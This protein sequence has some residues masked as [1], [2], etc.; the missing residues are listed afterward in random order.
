MV[1]NHWWSNRPP[2]T[3]IPAQYFSTAL[4]TSPKATAAPPVISKTQWVLF[5]KRLLLLG[6]ILSFAWLPRAQAATDCTAVTEI[7]QLECEALVALYTSTDGANWSDSSD[8]NWNVTN[9]PCS[10]AGVTCTTEHVTSIHRAS[11][12]LSGAI[13]TGLGNLSQL[14]ALWLDHNQL[15]DSLPVSLMSLAGLGDFR[16]ND[17]NLCEPTETDFQNWL[18]SIDKLQRTG[19]QCASLETCHDSVCNVVP[20]RVEESLA[21]KSLAEIKFDGLKESY[22]V[23][24]TITIRVVEE[25]NASPR[26]ESVD[27]WVAMQMPT[28]ELFFKTPSSSTPFSLE[29]QP[30][31]TGV[32][33]SETVHQV[34]EFKVPPG[35]E[36]KYTLF[37]IYVQ[38]G[39]NPLLQ[40]IRVIQRSNLAVSAVV[41]RDV[42]VS[43]RPLIMRTAQLIEDVR[44]S[45]AAPGWKDARLTTEVFPLYRPDVEGIAYY[46]LRVLVPQENGKGLKPAGFVIVSTGAHDFPVV[47]WNFEGK[48]PV[49]DLTEQAA[50][51]GKRPHTFYKLDTLAYAVE[52]RDGNL[53]ATISDLPPKIIGMNM[54]LLD[55]EAEDIV[56][57][58]STQGKQITKQQK[59]PFEFGEWTSWAEFKNEYADTYAVLIEALRRDASEEWEINSLIQQH[60]EVLFR[61]DNYQLATLPE[62]QAPTFEL[63]GEGV[64]FVEVKL[65]RRPAISPV[66]SINVIAAPKEVEVPLNVTLNYGDA[67]SQTMTFR[68]VPDSL[69]SEIPQYPPEIDSSNQRRSTR[70][71]GSWHTYW[72][73]THGDQRWYNQILAG[74][75][76]NNSSCASGCGATAWGMLFGWGDYRAASGDPVWQH[77]WG[78]YR[79]DGGDGDDVVAPQ[80]MD[81][82]VKNMLWEIRNDIDT[83]CVGSSGATYPWKMQNA[84]EYLQSR[85][86]ADISTHYNPIGIPMATLRNHAVDSIV[87]RDTPAVIGTGWLSHYP[88]AYGYKWRSYTFWGVTLFYQRKFYVNQGWGGSGNGW[89][90]ARTWFVGQ[91]YPSPN[92]PPTS[93]FTLNDQ[94]SSVVEICQNEPII[95]DGSASTDASGYFVSVQLSDQ[96]WNRY[97]P[98]IMRWLS[99]SEAANISYFDIIGFVDSG[100]SFQPGQYYRVKLAVGSPW[101]EN[102]KLVYIRDC[103]VNWTN[104]LDRDDPGGSGDWEDRPSFGSSVCSNPIDIEAR[105]KSDQ[106]DAA[107]TGEIFFHYDPTNGFVCRKVDQPDNVCF[108]YEVR[109]RCP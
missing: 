80:Y 54:D 28:G 96:W 27:L 75:S 106:V 70:G 87:N 103:T 85:T 69:V 22:D 47:H 78:L 79:E 50:S 26:A 6:A 94:S 97:G 35:I 65:I 24:E 63:N 36:G 88:L 29:P 67:I 92:P 19:V 31:K 74:V 66:L 41:L 45:D 104:W 39:A 107:M 71:W 25:P 77:S 44:N 30:F 21:E 62:M 59:M 42:S 2:L 40:D 23:G 32:K 60:G 84:D 64:K 33:L 83:F 72:A 4:E 93:S 57:L 91:L 48:S 15:T 108:D 49:Q 1:T 56:V 90:N 109:F 81:S 102:T 95:M 34:F 82:G 10:W 101:H 14:T 43:P 100:L 51:L 76:P 52:D 46:E 37:A 5:G 3:S 58:D 20:V 99:P 16:F 13:P 12:G 89:I 98:E 61:G 38:E 68:I 8:N 18:A 9:T 86:G 17:T 73:R 55:K 53:I 7:P 11:N 105:R